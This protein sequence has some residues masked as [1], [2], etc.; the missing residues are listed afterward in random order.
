[1]C[2]YRSEVAD[3]KGDLKT[4][5]VDL[6]GEFR[7]WRDKAVELEERARRELKGLTFTCMTGVDMPVA[8]TL[9]SVTD[10]VPRTS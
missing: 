5:G 8:A 2:I 4:L 9:K 10:E 3:L 7:G 1:M 6:S